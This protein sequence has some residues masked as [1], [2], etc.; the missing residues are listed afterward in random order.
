MRRTLA[1]VVGVVLIAGCGGGSDDSN[2][3]GGSSGSESSSAQ[4]A[5]D[6]QYIDPFQD[7]AGRGACLSEREVDQKIGRIVGR[8]Q[9]PDRRQ[10]AIKAAKD[11]AC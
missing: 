4:S 8:V 3:G 6:R 9:D 11:R 10:R 7:P 2:S 1:W 5:G